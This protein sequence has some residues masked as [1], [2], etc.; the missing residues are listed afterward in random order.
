MFQGQ[1]CG[2]L[3]NNHNLGV[4]KTGDFKLI[5]MFDFNKQL[6]PPPVEKEQ[7]L[8]Q[9]SGDGLIARL[10]QEVPCIVHVQV[11]LDPVRKVPEEVLGGGERREKLINSTQLIAT[12][13]KR[14][15]LFKG[16]NSQL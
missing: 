8:L 11:L 12:V 1:S 5:Y 2:M 13:C 10:N 16:A 14:R 7:L 9:V 3:L 4:Q 15:R 6:P